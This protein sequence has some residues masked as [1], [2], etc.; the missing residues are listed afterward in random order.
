MNK[1]L[2]YT[3]KDE[4]GNSLVTDFPYTIS[5][6]IQDIIEYKFSEKYNIDYNYTTWYLEE[7]AKEFVKDLEYKWWHNQLD[8]T[9]LYSFDYKFVNWLKDKYYNEA[10]EEALNH[11]T[12]TVNSDYVQM[13]L[14]DFL[15]ESK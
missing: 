4:N 8:T 6:N 10:Y 3:F 14:F 15:E 11:C 1:T 7:G 2:Y 9:E 5:E 12:Y 13:S